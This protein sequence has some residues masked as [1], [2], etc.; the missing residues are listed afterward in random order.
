MA[1]LA[2][3]NDEK[4]KQKYLKRI[5]A[6]EKADEIE[7]GYYWENGKGCA[8][9]CTIHSSDHNKY[10]KELGIPDCLAH[11]KDRLFEGLPNKKAKRFPR[12]FLEAI[13]PGVDLEPVKGKFFHWLLVDPVDGVITFTEK[14]SEQAKAI[15]NVADLWEAVNNNKPVSDKQWR[16]ARAAAGAADR[17]AWD[18]G[19]AAWAARAAAGAAARAAWD[20]WDAAG[21]AAWAARAAARAA[22][23]AAWDAHYE[24]MADK[25]LELLKAEEVNHD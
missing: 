14:G 25:L 19:A 11:L 15:Q 9:G 8:V 21:D 1:L 13:Q 3:H 12:Q 6:H 20:A 2:Y 7:K 17:A 4:I 23:D 18:A 22:W 24:R 16:H 5:K 10:E